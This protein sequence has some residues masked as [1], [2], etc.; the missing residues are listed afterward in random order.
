M[1][2]PSKLKRSSSKSAEKV[3]ASKKSTPDKSFII[4]RKAPFPQ[5]LPVNLNSSKASKLREQ[6]QMYFAMAQDS[7]R[8][9]AKPFLKWAGG[10]SSTLRQLEEFFPREIH[11]YIEPFLG[12]GAVFFFLK[13]R[14]P[15]MKS[16]LRDSNKV[17]A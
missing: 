1:T 13:H 15:N 12:G 17:S 5:T 14:F 4:R 10:K 2:A 8:V 16:F 6:M 9:E 7:V 11:R 3:Q